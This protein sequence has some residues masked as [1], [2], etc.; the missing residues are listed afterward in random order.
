M[1]SQTSLQTFW[2]SYGAGVFSML[3]YFLKNRWFDI[4]EIEKIKQHVA[5]IDYVQDD[6][7]LFEDEYFWHKL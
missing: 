5:D 7:P 6:S 1:F 4:A 2:S 3:L